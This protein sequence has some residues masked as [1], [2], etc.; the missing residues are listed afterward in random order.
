MR[1]DGAVL[2]CD[3]TGVL[4]TLQPLPARPER[5][6]VVGAVQ[7]AVAHRNMLAAVDVYAVALSN[8]AVF[9]RMPSAAIRKN[10]L[11]IFILIPEQEFVV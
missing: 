9:R 1:R 6:A 11:R 4:R 7:L 5:N 2:D 3:V 8:E 10:R